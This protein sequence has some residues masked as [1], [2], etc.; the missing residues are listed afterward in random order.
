MLS[1]SHTQPPRLE[2][3]EKVQWSSAMK[4]FIKDA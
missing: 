1:L 2:D 3:E 4:D